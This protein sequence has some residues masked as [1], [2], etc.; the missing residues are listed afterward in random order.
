[1]KFNVQKDFP[2]I[3]KGEH[4]LK[5]SSIEIVQF[6]DKYGK[7]KDGKVD[8]VKWRFV[9]NEEDEDGTPYDFV[10]YTGDQYGNEKAAMTR[11]I[12][13]LVPGMTEAKFPDYETDDLIGKKFKATIKHVKKDDGKPKADYVYMAPIGKAG[14]AAPKAAVTTV[15]D[16]DDEFKDPFGDD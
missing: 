15:A 3:P 14:A 9:S 7:G 12:D 2:L 16:D 13:N 8:R 5:L 4:I 6:E 11:L 10:V 1:M